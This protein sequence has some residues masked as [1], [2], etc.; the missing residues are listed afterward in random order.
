[1]KNKVRCGPHCPWGVV[2]ELAGH[3]TGTAVSHMQ[4]GHQH[5]GAMAEAEAGPRHGDFLSKLESLACVPFITAFEKC[6]VL[7][8]LILIHVVP[9][10]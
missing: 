9:C 6:P 2:N 3:R 8:T 1:M 7:L 10:C 4:R 5:Q